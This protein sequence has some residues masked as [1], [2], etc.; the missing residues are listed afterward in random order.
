MGDPNR[1]GTLGEDLAAAYLLAAGMTLV[2][3]N[4]RCRHGEIDII[5]AD[6]PALVF[7]EVKTRSGIGFGSPLAAIT[8]AKQVRLRRLVSLYLAEVGGHRGPI[9]IDAVGVQCGSG[10]PQ[11]Q[12]LR[13]VA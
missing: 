5:A 4:W 10:K 6:G 9:R 13:A 2:R 12:Y 3:R 11:L 7:C 1:L 8:A